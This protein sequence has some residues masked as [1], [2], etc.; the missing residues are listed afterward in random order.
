VQVFD[1]ADHVLSLFDL[2]LKH[3]GHAFYRMP[4][5][6]A[7]LRWVQLPLGRDL[8]HSLGSCTA[9]APAQP[10][11][12]HSLGS[13]TVLSSRSAS[14]ATVALKLSQKFRRF[15]IF[16]SILWWWIHLNTLSQFARPLH[17]AVVLILL[18]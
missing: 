3:P 18:Q 12:P 10:W 1:L 7:H 2:D 9:L 17:S 4:C 8:L 6:R 14:S 13:R 15:A 16:A 5:P 11:L